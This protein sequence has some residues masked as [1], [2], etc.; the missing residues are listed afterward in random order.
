MLFYLDNSLIVDEGHDEYI[1]ILKSV[2]NLAT[3][4]VD[5]NHLL[6][7]EVE[8]IRHFRAIFKSDFI[9]GPLFQ[10]L[11]SNMA[12]SSIPSS[13]TY[14]MEITRGLNNK[15][16]EGN[17]TI[18][19]MDYAHFSTLDISGKTIVI[20]EDL[21]D[22]KFFEHILK[23]YIKQTHFNLHYC[24]HP[25]GGN[26]HNTYRV[27]QNELSY[28][29]ITICIIDTDKRFSNDNPKPNST[30]SLCLPIG[31]GVPYYIFI[32]LNVHEIENLIPLN[33]LDT[34][35]IWTSSGTPNDRH[36]KRAFDF[37]RTQA[38]AL[39]PY[40]DY[41]KGIHKTEDLM[42]D[43]DYMYFA[44]MC[45]NANPDKRA[46]GISFASY[47]N[48]IGDNQIVY[49]QLL[50]GSGLLTRTIQLI[51]SRQCPI[52]ILERFQ[53]SEWMKIGQKMLNWCISRNSEELN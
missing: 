26:G 1:P 15:R 17:N 4:A 27:V 8:V 33:Y 30:Y 14:Y 20:G 37:L 18:I 51:D 47:L 9:V 11:D 43:S 34:F 36:N 39:L 12:F 38:N 25:I 31:I 3:Q 52:P 16:K 5:G 42:S 22:V 32:P 45:Y 24:L 6:L 53:E 35:D 21:N 2:H 46:S 13:V 19:Q 23:W 49:E 7:G 41:K 29:H 40:F 10:Y 28:E 48:S 44:E 50:G